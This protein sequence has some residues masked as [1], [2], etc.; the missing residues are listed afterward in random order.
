MLGRDAF[1]LRN[2]Q[3]REPDDRWQLVVALDELILAA[4]AL[5]RMDEAR[6]HGE[7]ALGLLAAY[8]D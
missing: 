3:L 2:P 4:R 6:R 1:L 7:E 8:D 5:G